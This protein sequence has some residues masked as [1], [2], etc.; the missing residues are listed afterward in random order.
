MS[1]N[2]KNKVKKDKVKKTRASTILATIFLNILII[3][4][5]TEILLRI[6]PQFMIIAPAWT[7]QRQY[8]ELTHFFT[9]PEYFQELQPKVVLFGDS[10]TRGAEVPPGHNW[11]QLLQKKLNT[12]VLN[13][14]VGGS[15]LVDPALMAAHFLKQA[16][17]SVKL[18]ILGI[19]ENDFND[20]FLK[21]KKLQQHGPKIFIQNIGTVVRN[22]DRCH[23]NLIFKQKELFSKH[24]DLYYKILCRVKGSYAL[25]M[26][27]NLLHTPLIGDFTRPL[28]N[29][30]NDLSKH[31][32]ERRSGLYLSRGEQNEILK[33]ANDSSF[34]DQYKNQINTLEKYISIMRSELQKRNISFL[35]VYFPSR[36]EVYQKEVMDV[37]NIPFDK[38]RNAGEIIDSI[39]K[40]Q[41][42][43]FLNL[44]GDFHKQIESKSPLFLKLNIH[45]SMN[46]HAVVANVIYDYILAHKN[47]SSNLM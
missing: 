20:T 29:E 43:M 33:L 24:N 18:A 22:Y 15:S 46:G 6:F 25:S 17:K 7:H 5:L 32:F 9:S 10:F 47:L 41:R 14:G 40:K 3:F 39:C 11:A 37:F 12:P 13:L 23:D 2:K 30:V 38:Y 45:M 8:E 26:L 1:G 4:F 35:I 21:D 36:H 44:T 34:N 42:I 27:N 19:Y 28:L 31:I 16:P